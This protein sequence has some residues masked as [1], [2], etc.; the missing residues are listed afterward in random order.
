MD[1]NF[2]HEK[3]TMCGWQNQGWWGIMKNRLIISGI[4]MQVMQVMEFQKHF[5]NQS[6]HHQNKKNDSKLLHRCDVL[7]SWGQ[8]LLVALVALMA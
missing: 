6:W 2:C 5:K 4:I 7:N 3:T 8:A 1:C